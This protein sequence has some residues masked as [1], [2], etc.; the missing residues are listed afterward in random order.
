[1]FLKEQ[2]IYKIIQPVEQIIQLIDFTDLF[3]LFS[4]FT[5]ILRKQFT[6]SCLDHMKI[7]STIIHTNSISHSWK[8]II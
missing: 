4:I 7:A 8:N 2:L 5:K 1:M 6:P 3:I